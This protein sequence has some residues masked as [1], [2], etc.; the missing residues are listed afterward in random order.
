M[1]AKSFLLIL[2]L[3]GI[4][5]HANSF[6]FS[7][8]KA[9]DKK[10]DSNSLI[11]IA[12]N[13]FNKGDF[14]NAVKAYEKILESYPN[15]SYFR[16]MLAKIY[17]EKINFGKAQEQLRKAIEI[18]P[19]NVEARYYLASI[20]S[21]MGSYKQTIDECLK[22]LEIDPQFYIARLLLADAYMYELDDARAEA[23]L[24]KLLEVTPESLSIHWRL[25]QVFGG[26]QG[27]LDKGISEMERVTNKKSDVSRLWE[28]LG[29]FYL[30]SSDFP[31]AVESCKKSIEINP[32]NIGSH[33]GLGQAYQYLDKT[34]EALRHFKIVL[35]K[36][37]RNL[38]LLQ[39]LAGI[40]YRKGDYEK[41]RDICLKGGEFYPH[42]PDFHFLLG[43]AYYNLMRGIEF[44]EKAEE[45]LKAALQLKPNYP[46]A[47]EWLG[48][49]SQQLKDYRAI[50]A[51]LTNIQQTSHYILRT[52]LS[53]VIL[54]RLIQEG[55]ADKIFEDA[56]IFFSKLLKKEIK[57]APVNVSIFNARRDFNQYYQFKYGQEAAGRSIVQLNEIVIDGNDSLYIEHLLLHETAHDILLKNVPNLPE[58][59]GEALSGGL[60]FSPWWGIDLDYLNEF[61]ASSK[62]ATLNEKTIMEEKQDQHIY[63]LFGAFL[64]TSYYPELE[65]YIKLLRENKNAQESFSLAFR[66]KQSSLGS[67]F[68]KFIKD[69]A[70][71]LSILDDFV[72]SEQ[73]RI[74]YDFGHA[75]LEPEDILLNMF[76][77]KLY[78]A[79]ALLLEDNVTAERLKSFIKRESKPY[80][81][82]FSKEAERL[83]FLASQKLRGEKGLAITID[84]YLL[85]LLEDGNN[86]V[87]SIL[88]R[89]GIDTINLRKRF[90]E[91]LEDF[92][93]G[94]G[95]FFLLA[96][97]N[98]LPG[99]S[100]ALYYRLLPED[101]ESEVLLNNIKLG[102]LRPYEK[103]S[104]KKGGLESY[105][106]K[107]P[108]TLKPGSYNVEIKQNGETLQN[109]PFILT[110][111]LSAPLIEKIFV[112]PSSVKNAL[113]RN[114][115]SFQ[116]HVAYWDEKFIP[117]FHFKQKGKTFIAQGS[118]ENEYSPNI[119]TVNIPHEVQVGDVEIRLQAVFGRDKSLTSDPIYLKV[120]EQ[121]LPRITSL[122]KYTFAPGE[123]VLIKGKNFSRLDNAN[124]VMIGSFKVPA[125]LYKKDNS[126]DDLLSEIMGSGTQTLEIEIPKDKGIKGKVSVRVKVYDKLSN[127][128]SLELQNLSKQ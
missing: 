53:E 98:V 106:L 99:T 126:E 44:V 23:E 30:R 95:R 34:D 1:K 15:N 73:R 20:F 75:S 86:E 14:E 4:W 9:E 35:E 84:E 26:L 115:S 117:V 17:I 58:W 27:N 97:R 31:K 10:E 25:A 118:I 49:V 16:L 50:S 100:V 120:F 61:M 66:D 85:T 3:S 46:Q 113:F 72:S 47:K 39:S 60:L 74:S 37:P 79:Q 127:E 59:L 45:Q 94:E 112:S 102:G 88:K 125:F 40:Y 71:K 28:E 121:G 33:Y 89:I 32:Q 52:D 96:P 41:L 81:G 90:S 6:Y 80:Y 56:R 22:A 63:N 128:V 2:L 78:I 68:Q 107:I 82:T 54:Y 64:L 36:Q 67:E 13:Y 122:N 7:T 104:Y 8:V 83:L 21:M 24:K 109:L 116:F 19:N 12:Q 124:E 51:K 69:M 123:K 91:S 5:I 92:K 55:I 57:M 103:D 111:Q 119:L 76:G 38:W 65:E 43:V 105:S 93:N 42:N 110:D 18:N 87:V 11:N 77:P 48:I 62:F 101:K 70:S 108:D 29:L 114:L